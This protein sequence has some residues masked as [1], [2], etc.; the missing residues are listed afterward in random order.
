MNAAIYLCGHGPYREPRFL[1]M[2]YLRLQRYHPAL[3]K[4]LGQHIEVK[5]I[6]MDLNFPR[7]SFLDDLPQLKTLLED[8]EKQEIDIVLVDI[9]L[10]DSFHTYTYAP[11][12]RTIEHAGARVYNGYYDDEDALLSELRDRYGAFVNAYNLPDD[13]EEFVTLFPALAGKVTYEALYD[14]LSLV[15]AGNTDPFLSYIRNRIDSLRNENPY[16]RS[17]L[18]WLSD[19]THEELYQ[20][21]Q[22]E[23]DKRRDTEALFV[24]GPHQPGKLLDEGIYAPRDP[25][26]LQW[27]IDR[28]QELGFQPVKEERRQAWI[29]PYGD[30]VLYADPRTTGSIDI[31]VYRQD[32]SP[33]SKTKKSRSAG[34]PIGHFRFQDA[35][36]HDLHKKLTDRVEAVILSQKK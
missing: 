24:L 25:D 2:Q 19:R 22:K 21:R 23:R 29:L 11:I 28:L 10:G 26:D 1:E 16:A 6:Y 8:I 34:Y 36:K 33:Q 20:L 12:I 15:P 7:T 32:P 18:P 14:R 35:W 5:H 4:K 31:R 3:E 13:Q 17:Q 27:V 30:Y 9:C